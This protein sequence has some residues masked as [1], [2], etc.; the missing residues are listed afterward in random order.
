MF[1][2]QSMSTETLL[3]SEKRSRSKEVPSLVDSSV[4]VPEKCVNRA[5]IEVYDFNARPEK[6]L[7][8]P[9]SAETSGPSENMEVTSSVRTIPEDGKGILGGR[10]RPQSASESLQSR[11]ILKLSSDENANSVL[12]GPCIEDHKCKNNNHNDDD[13]H[14]RRQV[15]NRNYNSN[16]TNMNEVNRILNM[17]KERETETEEDSTQNSG[18]KMTETE[19][20]KHLESLDVVAVVRKQN[21]HPSNTFARNLH[22]SEVRPNSGS[23]TL[24]NE[25]NQSAVQESSKA[26]RDVK[27]SLEESDEEEELEKTFMEG[28]ESEEAGFEN[29]A[30]EIDGDTFVDGQD[31]V[32]LD[33]T[34]QPSDVSE[35]AS[36]KD[37]LNFLDEN[38]NF[39]TTGSVV[40]SSLESS[41]LTGSVSSVEQKHDSQRDDGIF[42]DNFNE[43]FYSEDDLRSEDAFSDDAN[44]NIDGTRQSNNNNNC[45]LQLLDNNS[46]PFKKR[47]PEVGKLPEPTEAS[48]KFMGAQTSEGELNEISLTFLKEVVKSASRDF[49]PDDAIG[50]AQNILDPIGQVKEASDTIGQ[51]EKPPDLMNSLLKEASGNPKVQKLKEVG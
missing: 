24:K 47:S 46:S 34:S 48:P 17:L 9:D 5:P 45:R 10:E 1:V 39:F 13:N 3:R 21:T 35:S 37:A 30:S 14:G 33:T 19:E 49:E 40:N 8:R 27:D 50:Q 23:S 16:E 28:D 29:D 18:V 31:D 11:E 43:A 44:N 32:P 22:T 20:I 41:G 6:I 25:R 51:I 36:V 15:N 4:D 2:M 7:V 42:Y 38:I 12:S 26:A